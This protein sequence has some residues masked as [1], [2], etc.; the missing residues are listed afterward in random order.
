MEG[1]KEEFAKKRNM[2]YNEFEM[3]K[4][5]REAQAEE[6]EDEDEDDDED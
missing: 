6:D 2:H 4:R 5:F 1:D 3:L